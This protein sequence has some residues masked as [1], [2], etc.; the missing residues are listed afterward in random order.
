MLG[1]WEI[2]TLKLGE[3]TVDKSLETLGKDIGTTMKI[4]VLAVAIYGK[5]EKYLWTPVSRSPNG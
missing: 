1:I 5:V 4:P 3:F 2:M